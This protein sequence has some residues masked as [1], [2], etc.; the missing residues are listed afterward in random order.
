MI[1]LAFAL[2]AFAA[3]AALLWPLLRPAPAGTERAVYDL[4]VF[5]DQLA[6]VDRDVDR[7]VLTAGEASAAR[8]EIQRRMLAS[9]R[10]G[11]NVV[12]NEGP[13]ARGLLTAGLAV[14]VPF[15]A[16][17]L[18]MTVGAPQLAGAP[19]DSARHEETDVAALVD[20]LAARMRQDP[21]N[22]EG[23]SLL[24]RSY[25]QMERFAD[26]AEA[27]RNLMRL[28]PDEAEGYA[29]FGEAATAAAGGTV[30][31][32]ARTALLRALALDRDETRARFYLGLER[33]QANDAKNAIAI[34]RDLTATAP[35]DASWL[36]AVRAQMAQVAQEAGVM[37]MQVAPRHP[38]DVFGAGTAPPA[39]ADPAAPDMT[40]LQGRFSADNLEMIQGMVG[41][42]A[43]RL[44]ANPGDYDGWM[45]L[46]RSYGV[47]KN[48]AGARQAYV[49]AAALRLE[50]IAPRAQLADLLLAAGDKTAARKIWSDA[51]A[52]LPP[53]SPARAEMERRRDALR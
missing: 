3:V 34:W 1:W 8:I 53:N 45:L 16:L 2:L 4:A 33:A 23:W 15:A 42:L 9:A 44:E 26:A 36:G 31:A 39:A 27:Y 50:E 30:T 37:P 32:E 52:A 18:Y 47:L 28:K 5:R 12:R 10:R 51:L 48:D 14:A 24:A 35:A 29:G 20:K 46:G 11:E 49:R 21:D 25:R 43:A 38:L 19:R 40:A 13:Q 17:A 22:A 6:E 7:G 41:G